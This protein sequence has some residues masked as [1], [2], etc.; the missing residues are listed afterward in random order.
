MDNSIHHETRR[1]VVELKTTFNLNRFNASLERYH[2]PLSAAFYRDLSRST[3][4][5]FVVIQTCE[6]YEIATF[7][8]SRAQLHEGR[9]QWQTALERFDACW[10]TGE[11][12][13]AEPA[14]P[15]MDDDPLLMN[16]M[17]RNQNRNRFDLPLGELAL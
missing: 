4:V 15:A 1:G 10:K 17:R 3:S 7:A 8:M 13:E 6:P 5:E 2:Y 11:W 12:P 14:A 16:F 9:E